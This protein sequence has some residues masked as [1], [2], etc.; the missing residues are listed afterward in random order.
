MAPRLVCNQSTIAWTV[1]RMHP[2]YHVV[3]PVLPLVTMGIVWHGHLI[4]P[5]PHSANADWKARRG[6]S[7]EGTEHDG[8][9]PCCSSSRPFRC[10]RLSMRVISITCN[11]C[12][13]AALA[14][15]IFCL[16]SMRILC[17]R[18]DCVGRAPKPV[19]ATM[20]CI[21]SATGVYIVR[22]IH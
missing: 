2:D 12:L 14:L 6:G 21:A 16:L 20:T 1:P 5:L 18:T 19:I 13:S 22:V 15:T 7:S 17:A 3:K 8:A 9:T 4:S 10:A 11:K